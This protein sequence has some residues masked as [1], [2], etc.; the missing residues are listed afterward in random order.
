MME[1]RECNTTKELMSFYDSCL[2]AAKRR[3]PGGIVM[4]TVA[5]Q[6]LESTRKQLEAL[7]RT[8]KVERALALIEGTPADRDVRALC[9]HL[10]KYYGAG[11]S[12]RG[13]PFLRACAASMESA[14]VTDPDGWI[15]KALGGD[16]PTQR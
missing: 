7:P 14:R 1:W 5:V 11:A 4:L 15:V 8:S 6:A 9:I 13:E 12:G 10:V 2:I 3:E 16:T